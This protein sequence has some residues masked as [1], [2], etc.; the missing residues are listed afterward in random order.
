MYPHN[1]F[2]IQK[3][4][5]QFLKRK[6]FIKTCKINYKKQHPENDYKPDNNQLYFERVT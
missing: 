1:I 4:L 5:G 2:E 3:N 6:L